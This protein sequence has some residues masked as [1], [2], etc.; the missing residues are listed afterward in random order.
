MNETNAMAEKVRLAHHENVIH[1]ETNL[2]QPYAPIFYNWTILLEN[3]SADLEGLT[4]FWQQ[5]GCADYH[6]H[7]G[8]TLIGEIKL[9]ED[10]FQQKIYRLNDASIS[11][12]GIVPEVGE[13]AHLLLHLQDRECFRD[14]YFLRDRP[15]SMMHT[16]LNFVK[17]SCEVIYPSCWD[18]LLG[19]VET[20]QPMAI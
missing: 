15:S 11:Y 3:I 13:R 1:Q 8:C 12:D 16:V 10:G 7:H 6:F 20:A 17:H 18:Y 5:D 2:V 9:P 14:F 4:R 19:D